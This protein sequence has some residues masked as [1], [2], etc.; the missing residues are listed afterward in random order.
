[1]GWLIGVVDAVVLGVFPVWRLDPEQVPDPGDIG[2]PVAV[3]KEAVVADA[4]LTLGQDVDQEPSDEFLGCERHGGV[5]FGAIQAVGNGG[6]KL[7]HGSAAV[8]VVRAA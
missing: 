3:S 4:V 1:M 6:A 2:G 8:L 7:D 5:S